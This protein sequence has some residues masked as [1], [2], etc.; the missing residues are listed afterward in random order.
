MRKKYKVGDLFKYA[1]D[2]GDTAYAILKEI[3]KDGY[4]VIHWLDLIGSPDTEYLT[5]FSKEDMDK[6]F[7]KI[8]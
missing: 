5:H 7:R 2:S 1:D 3:D 8:Q 6:W 4:H